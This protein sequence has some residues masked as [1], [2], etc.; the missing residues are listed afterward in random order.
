MIILPDSV[1]ALDIFVKEKQGNKDEK[2][3]GGDEDDGDDDF[4][5]VTSPFEALN[6][7]TRR[8]YSTPASLHQ[9]AVVSALRQKYTEAGLN[10]SALQSTGAG[11][12]Q[13]SGS[14][15]LSSDSLHAASTSALID[16][17]PDLRD[18]DR[19]TSVST[20]TCNTALHFMLQS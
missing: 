13:A 10:H 1:S 20:P 14:A 6:R 17:L 2:L 16:D 8:R 7:A 5:M 9:P 4:V 18:C 12:A 19:L 15:R 3:D 11:I